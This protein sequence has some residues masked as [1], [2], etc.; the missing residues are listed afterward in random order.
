ML[1][2]F[3]AWIL[4][5]YIGDYFGNVNTHQL[6]MSL[7][8]G[9][10]ELEHLPLK[11]DL[12]RYLGLPL[13]ANDGFIG[14]ISIKFPSWSSFTSEPLVIS[15]EDLFLIVKPITNFSYNE[16]EENRSQQEFKISQ[17]DMM[18]QRWK[19]LHDDDL[20][21]PHS[22]YSSSYSSW[23]NY[24]SSLI[25]NVLMNIHLKISSIHVR[26]EDNST[27]PGCP[28]ATGIV[29]RSLTLCSTDENWQPKFVTTQNH[30][31]ESN[32]NENFLF[33]LIDLE[34]FA[35]YMDTETLLFGEYDLDTMVDHMRQT[36]DR[37]INHKNI[38]TE[39]DY[40]I[41]PVNGKCFMKRNCTEMS[42]KS[43]KQPRT[44]IDVQLERVPIMM[45]AIQYKHLFDWSLAF[46]TQKTLWRYQYRQRRQRFNWHFILQRVRDIIGYH[47]AYICYLIYPESFSRD[48]RCLKERVENEFTLDELCSIREIV[49]WRANQI[50]K[51]QMN[52]S[53]LN[54]GGNNKLNITEQQQ[55]GGGYWFLP[56]NVLSNLYYNYASTTAA[57]TTTDQ[58]SP[59][60]DIKSE[61]QDEE[62][63]MDFHSSKRRHLSQSSLNLSTTTITDDI[64]LT[65]D[66]TTVIIADDDD[67]QHSNLKMQKIATATLTGC[68]WQFRFSTNMLSID[69]LYELS[70]CRKCFTDVLEAYFSRSFKERVRAATTEVLRGIVPETTTTTAD[71]STA[72]QSNDIQ[73]TILSSSSS[74]LLRPTSSTSKLSLFKMQTKSHGRQ[75]TKFKSKTKSMANPF[76]DNF[77]LNIFIR[78][79]IIICPISPSSYE[80]VVFHLGHMLLNN[81]NHSTDIIRT[82]GRQ[83]MI[84]CKP[85]SQQQRQRKFGITVNQS[86]LPIQNH[87]TNSSSSTTTTTSTSNNSYNAEIRDLSIYSLDCV[88][89]IEKFAQRKHYP[90]DRLNRSQPELYIPVEKFYYCDIIDPLVLPKKFSIRQHFYP[91]QL[92]SS[93]FIGGESVRHHKNSKNITTA[94]PEMVLSIEISTIDVRFSYTDLLVF[95][96]I[97][98]TLTSIEQQPQPV[99]SSIHPP[100][101]LDQNKTVLNNITKTK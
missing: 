37:N 100:S 36:L 53:D 80:V 40:M 63:E 38:P 88:K 7:K 74:Q 83:E 72:E 13:E 4:N 55:S 23:L 85:S 96:H 95:W 9:E 11:R 98:N 26:Y 57:T 1:E 67:D 52:P 54:N 68:G 16:E 41:A 62:E 20:A 28:F 29:I 89:N 87:S 34:S 5:T 32:V 42:L 79:P 27:I 91:D 15:I 24:G 75:K 14:K 19:A 58:E 94:K 76:L 12:I 60:E 18:E 90:S 99:S 78:S 70:L 33:K 21:E 77:K 8:N 56:Y 45:T 39:H 69:G 82:I 64:F 3:A 17:L 66:I 101:A 6:R 10:I 44:V 73:S 84:V 46:Q 65:H 50:L 93:S 51:R 97:L 2:S 81:H 43:C 86:P 31:G 30:K 61:Q 59:T 22:Y 92:S 47:R 35:C 48:L 71:D 25:N 49:F